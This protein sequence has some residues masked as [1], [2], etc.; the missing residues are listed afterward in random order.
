MKLHRSELDKRESEL[1]LLNELHE[2]GY[3]HLFPEG[4]FG[5]NAKITHTSLSKKQLKI[6]LL[7]FE[8]TNYEGIDVI[9]VFNSKE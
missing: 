1:K 6:N 9:N 3:Y 7:E 5:K 4:M 8:L 2:K